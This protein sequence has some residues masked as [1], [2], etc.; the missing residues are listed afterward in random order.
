MFLVWLIIAVYFVVVIT[1]I[2]SC[3]LLKW[4]L[5]HEV[6]TYSYS[7]VGNC[8]IFCYNEYHRDLKND[9]IHMKY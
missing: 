2:V 9:Y 7:L 1:D 5:D 8:D 3:M 4:L 6:G